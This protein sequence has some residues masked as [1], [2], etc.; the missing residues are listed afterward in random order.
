[1]LNSKWCSFLSVD[2]GVQVIIRLQDIVTVREELVGEDPGIRIVV[3]DALGKF[4]YL[5]NTYDLEGFA[6]QVLGLRVE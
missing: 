5:T 3:E 2:D 4:A 1:M 6:T